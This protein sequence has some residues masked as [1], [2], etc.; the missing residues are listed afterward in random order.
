M[1]SYYFDTSVLL[2]RY[3]IEAGRD[4]VIEVLDPINRNH[5]FIAQ[6][7]PV[8]I[9]SGIS[10]LKSEGSISADD[11]HEARLLLKRHIHR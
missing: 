9:I 6:I 2:K 4:W 8:E 7:T 1:T 11:A 5:V 10:R 3:I